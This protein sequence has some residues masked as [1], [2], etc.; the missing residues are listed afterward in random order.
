ET[1]T[2]SGGATHT[3]PKNFYVASQANEM[4]SSLNRAFATIVADNTGSSASLAANSTR[5]DTDTR[6]FQAQFR[7]GIW[8]GELNAYSVDPLTGALSASPVWSATT[9]MGSV[10]W[11]A[12]NIRAANET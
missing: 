3:R 4:I 2:H 5:L 12:R 1:L 10:A 6:T 11:N 8:S 9:A 7:S